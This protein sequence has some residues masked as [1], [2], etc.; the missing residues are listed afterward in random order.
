MLI[1]TNSKFPADM[2]QIRAPSAP[3][4][5]AVALQYCAILQYANMCKH[6]PTHGVELD[7]DRT[8]FDETSWDRPLSES[9]EMILESMI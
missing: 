1:F 5:Q 2:P 3:V 6:M 9:P 8:V 4:F 7:V